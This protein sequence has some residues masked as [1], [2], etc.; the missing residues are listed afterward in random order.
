MNEKAKKFS[1]YLNDKQVSAFTTEELD[2]ELHSV[3]FRSRMDIRGNSLPTI[4]IWDDSIYGMIRVLVAPRALKESN[5]EGLL[6]LINGYN[7]KYKS[8][9][10]YVD[11]EGSLI[12]DACMLAKTNEADGDMVYIL[13]D[14]LVQ[15]LH[16]VYAEIMKAA[17]Q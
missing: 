4:I 9:K 16:E 8:F 17:W 12:L 2:D 5:K 3:V 11:D 15:H 14:V 10:Y 7:K 13:L 1:Q 6:D